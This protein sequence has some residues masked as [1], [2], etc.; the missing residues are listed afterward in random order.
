MGEAA[1]VELAC[2]WC[3]LRGSA[4]GATRCLCMI[5]QIDGIAI[6]PRSV[7]DR[8][9]RRDAHHLPWQ[10]GLRRCTACCHT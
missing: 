1:D 4:A 5:H 8:C 10:D 3:R 2:G 7:I 9:L 6:A